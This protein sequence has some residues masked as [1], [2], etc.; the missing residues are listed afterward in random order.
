[1]QKSNSS[2]MK[3]DAGKLQHEKEEKEQEDACTKQKVIQPR[4]YLFF[5]FTTY[6][7]LF[8]AHF[9]L[10]FCRLNYS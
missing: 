5:Y 3:E 10:I 4:P 2:V 8:K 1:M 7:K 9:D 6:S